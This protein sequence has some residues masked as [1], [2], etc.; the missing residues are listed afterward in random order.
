MK[1]NIINKAKRVVKSYLPLYL[2]ILLPLFNSC[3]DDFL[4]QKNT[5]QLS[6]S[7]FF[8]SDD[9]VSQA[10]IPLY[11]YVW[12]DFNDKFY[13]GMGDGR[14][15][16]I[17]A[18]YSDYIY[19]FTNFTETGLSTGLTE[20]WG[21]LY[22]VVAQ[23]NNSLNNI[24]EFSTSGV[25][26]TAKT[27]GIAEARFMRG[28]AYWYIASLWGCA[29]V[30][31]NTQTIINNYVISPNRLTDAMEFAIRDLEFAAVNLP[32]TSPATGR[33]NK[34][35]AYAVLSRLYLSM[36]GLTTSGR[37]DGNNIQTNAISGQRNEY[38]LDAA[39]KA[40]SIAIEK[41]PYKLLDNY[42]DLFAAATFNNNDEA[43]FQ[44]Q[45]QAGA[46]NGLAQSMARFL[47]WST[48]VNQ[49]NSWGGST[50][51]SYDLWEE[52]KE[53]ADP[54]LGVTIDDAIR[55]H[56]CVASYGEVYPELSA[57]ENPY[58]YGETENAGSQGA[59]IK[60]YVIGTNAVNGFAVNNNSGVNT[61][62]MRLAEVYLNYV[63]AAIG[64]NGSTNDAKALEYLNALRTRAGVASKNRISYEDLRH[65]FRVETA[66]EG[67]YWF[68][69]VRRAYYQQQEVVNYI[70]SQYRNASYYESS[71]HTY[72]LSENYTAPGPSVSTATARNLTLPMPDTDQTKNPL[73]KPDTNGQ[74]TTVPYEFGEREVT[75]AELF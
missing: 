3:A 25:S 26:E 63:D 43:I 11:S 41:G 38:Y 36:A 46:T 23:A 20:A 42:A 6:Q 68:F 32:A 12:Y 52:F 10:I 30:Y 28:L 1:T 62:M 17:T 14:A 31:D 15:N 8:A 53:Y 54:T 18:Q 48:Q 66:F 60:K 51:C 69:L 22:S 9:A 29:I 61:Y 4:D 37:Y 65:E 45:F 34:Y 13:Y 39:K 72:K 49:G 59:N 73:L 71:T 47:A 21:A 55:R 58:I 56:N 67:L 74:I 57:S 75:D 24:A 64:N 19:P 2:L 40:A 33:V 5:Y 27:Q 35:A 16:N 50:Y 70:N 7:N 44:L